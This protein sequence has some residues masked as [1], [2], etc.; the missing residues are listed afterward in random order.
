[1]EHIPAIWKTFYATNFEKKKKINYLCFLCAFC[2]LY[3]Y[4]LVSESTLSNDGYFFFFFLQKCLMHASCVSHLRKKK[5]FNKQQVLFR[6]WLA[7]NRI[8]QWIL[9][10]KRNSRNEM[11]RNIKKN[12]FSIVGKEILFFDI[13]IRNLFFFK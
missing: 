5:R 11:E 4:L 13:E 6:F 12:K 10:T 9:C 2:E 7:Y 3:I 1:M 8:L